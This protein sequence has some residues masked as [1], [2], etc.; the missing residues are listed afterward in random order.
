M[1]ITKPNPKGIDKAIHSFQSDLYAHLVK[2]GWPEQDYFAYGR[3]YKNRSTDGGFKAEV[4]NPSSND[5]TDVFWR[6]TLTALSFFG[7]GD[8]M[9]P[10]MVTDV[11]LVFFVDLKK[12]APEVIHR[13]DEEI[14][15]D[16]IDYALERMHGFNLVSVEVGMAN[17][18]REYPVSRDALMYID[19][20]PTHCFRLNFSVRYDIKN[21]C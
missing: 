9:E 5:Y 8:M 14:R 13:A 15:L 12:L 6:D 20:H 21:N 3:A 16:V 7:V 19:M 1:L 4:F 2:L 11:H 18:L 17:V 10:Y